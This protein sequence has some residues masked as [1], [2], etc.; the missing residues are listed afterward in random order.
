MKKF[1]LVLN[2]LQIQD[3]CWYLQCAIEME[4]QNLDDPEQIERMIKLLKR[5]KKQR[6]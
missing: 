1:N 5:L 2:P 4:S 3:L 6:N